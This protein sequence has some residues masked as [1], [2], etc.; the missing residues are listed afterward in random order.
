MTG[1]SYYW[2]PKSTYYCP[3]TP[4]SRRH[5]YP[6]YSS[7]YYYRDLKPI[8][9]S[10]CPGSPINR[11][12]NCRPP[13]YSAHRHSSLRSS[14]INTNCSHHY[15]CSSIPTYPI[16]SCRGYDSSLRICPPL[17][18]LSTRKRLMTHQAHAYHMVD[19]SPWP[20]TGAAAALLITSGLAI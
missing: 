8:H 16:R 1:H 15:N 20:L 5:T 4:P 18:P 6:A 13:S 11:K 10:S 3:R 14:A 17:K 9:S 2:P 12:P 19:P 7:S